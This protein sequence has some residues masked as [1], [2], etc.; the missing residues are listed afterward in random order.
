[1]P[2]RIATSPHVRAPVTV[3]T[4]MVRV[5]L[6]L[7]PGIAA[8]VW[9][10]GWG[11]VVNISIAVCTAIA[12]EALMLRI[13]R[14][15][16]M[17]FITDSSALVTATLLALA[18][19]PTMPWWATVIGVLFAIVVAKHL[20]GGLGY[21]PFNP[22]MVGYVVLLISFP[23]EMTMWFPVVSLSEYPLSFAEYVALIFT[24][25]LPAGFEMDALTE[26]TPLDA[27]RTHLGLGS[28]VGDIR[29]TFGLD[30]ETSRLLSVIPIFGALG[31]KG[32]EWVNAGFLAGGLW[33]LY[34][35]VIAWHIP[36]AV[37]GSLAVMSLLFYVYDPEYY[38]S[39]M[40]HLFSGA[41]MLG[42]FFI[43]T[44][45]VTAAV[46]PTGRLLYGVGIGILI[47][48]IRVW[49]G[50]PDSIAFAVLL[51]NMAVPLIDNYF[52]PRVFGHGHRKE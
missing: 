9:F 4:V 39:P 8:Y 11:V 20:Y 14:Q 16:V 22:A 3:A 25:R 33:L 42:A 49:G 28:T 48:V 50:Y 29:A 23:R 2:L 24:G 7:I 35:R 52:K 12:A 17:Q 40:F 37:L 30:E 15:P 21:N 43:A 1:M 5:L 44:D 6:A 27:L 34:K 47:Y 18:I 26:A 32:W 38:A 13:R 31:G 36:V 19:P 41:A 45:P 46:S 10:F 51:M